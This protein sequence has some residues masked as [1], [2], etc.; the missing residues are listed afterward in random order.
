MD[1]VNRLG[2]ER[3]RP[4]REIATIIIGEA[5]GAR[6]NGDHRVV[7][8]RRDGIEFMIVA[9]R[10]GHGEPEKGLRDDVELLVIDVV[11]HAL[12]ILLSQRFGAEREK[13]RRDDALHVHL[14][15]VLSGKKV[16]R[17]L[18]LHEA[19][20]RQVFIE[21]PDDVVAVAPSMRIANVLVVAR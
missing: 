4:T 14:A 18:L 11:E 5:F 20:I 8:P 12:F 10:A 15:A 3:E 13:A 19:D 1:F 7:I 17:N 21:G 9:T 6:K 16:A 2:H